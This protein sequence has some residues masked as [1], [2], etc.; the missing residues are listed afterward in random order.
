[1]MICPIFFGQTEGRNA[2]FEAFLT[3]FS[4]PE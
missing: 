1:M 3:F 2:A 4:N